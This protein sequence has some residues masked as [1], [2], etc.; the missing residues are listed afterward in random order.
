[1]LE[2]R[3][4]VLSSVLQ[5]VGGG[6]FRAWVGQQ[7]RSGYAVLSLHLPEQPPWIAAAPLTLAEGCCQSGRGCNKSRMKADSAQ[8][9]QIRLNKKATTATATTAMA[10][11]ADKRH[12]AE[13]RRKIDALPASVQC[14]YTSV[15][16]GIVQ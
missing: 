15:Y 3:A 12:S 11:M 9:V 6:I 7:R 13:K 1:M 16:I 8:A 5:Q 14:I 4:L 10:T 2:E